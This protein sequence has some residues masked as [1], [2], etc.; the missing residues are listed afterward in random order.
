VAD[1]RDAVATLRLKGV[2]KRRACLI[3]GL[4]RSSLYYRPREDRDGA[5]RQRLCELALNHPRYG[6]RRAWA[7]LRREGWSVNLKRIYRV[8]KELDLAVPRPRRRRRRV[9]GRDPVPVRA[10]HPGHVWTY[11]FLK[12]QCENGRAFRVYGGSSPSWSGY[13]PSMGLRNGC[14]RTTGRSSSPGR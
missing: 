13:S 12:D 7:M 14:A 10:E 3:L 9:G 4:G 5:L 8:W 11:D 1:R 2:S 6:Y